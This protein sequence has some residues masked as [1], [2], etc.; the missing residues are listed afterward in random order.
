[1]KFTKYN[2]PNKR[3]RSKAGYSKAYREERKTELYNALATCTTEA[4]REAVIK[5]YDISL[6]P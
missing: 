2:N 6:H 4:E 5:A 1:M 3:R